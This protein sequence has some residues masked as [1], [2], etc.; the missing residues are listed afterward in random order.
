MNV[1]LKQ[2][3]DSDAAQPR[4][5]ALKAGPTLVGRSNNCSLILSSQ[6]VSRWHCILDV[7]ADGIQVTDLHSLNG[8][9]V[10]DRRIIRQ[11]LKNDDQ[12]RIGEVS[13][14]VS[15]DSADQDL[16][17]TG[18]LALPVL[19]EGSVEPTYELAPTDFSSISSVSPRGRNH[20]KVTQRKSA[21]KSADQPVPELT[22][23]LASY[24]KAL[25]N[26]S[27]QLRLLIEKVI[28]LEAKLNALGFQKAQVQQQ[29]QLAP[30]KAFE[31]HDAMMYIA[32]AA[33]CDKVRQ[34]SS[35]AGQS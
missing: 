30:Q 29:S 21:E 11:L 17:P 8:T 23:Q 35:P 10:N 6:S 15:I 25:D 33:V 26:C 32:R 4:S 12:L 16:S 19:P 3:S 20:A 31:R 2:I 13:F 28:A 5:Y 7:T 18:A 22:R 14:L 9:Y 27:A 24:E 1:I 34:Q